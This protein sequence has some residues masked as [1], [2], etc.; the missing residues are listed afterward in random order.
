MPPSNLAI[1]PGDVVRL[2]PENMNIDDF[3]FEIFG[4]AGEQKNVLIKFNTV[5]T[6]YKTDY[7]TFV[8]TSITPRLF[9]A[10]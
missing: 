5:S 9:I 10:N 3:M 8:Q 4:E 7:K 1:K 2:T 6:V